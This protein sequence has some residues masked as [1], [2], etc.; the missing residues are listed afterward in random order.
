MIVYFRISELSL[1]I[2]RF[3]SPLTRVGKIYVKSADAME[4][5]ESKG[6]AQLMSGS[7]DGRPRL[8]GGL[9]FHQDVYIS[10]AIV[11]VFQQSGP[12]SMR[13]TFSPVGTSDLALHPC[14]TLCQCA[15]LRARVCNPDCFVVGHSALTSQVPDSPMF[16]TGKSSGRVSAVSVVLVL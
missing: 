9:D 14:Q 7:Y 10:Q 11:P 12:A 3:S 2:S 13:D 16:D 6:A 8:Q 1:M 15:E 4:R 5:T